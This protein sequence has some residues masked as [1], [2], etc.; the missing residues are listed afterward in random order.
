TTGAGS[1]TGPG[2]RG[3]PAGDDQKGNGSVRA[4]EAAEDAAL[5][6]AR[7]ETGL[8]GFRIVRKLGEVEYDITPLRF[9]IQ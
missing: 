6:E 5:R 3:S 7:E 4:G 1:H 9:E 2:D 8:T